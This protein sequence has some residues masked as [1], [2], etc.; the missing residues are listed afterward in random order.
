MVLVSLGG[1]EEA[2]AQQGY[3]VSCVC[4]ALYHGLL[5][6]RHIL[7]GVARLAGYS[8]QKRAQ[9]SPTSKDMRSSENLQSAS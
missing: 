8:I 4:D 3:F 5:K 1:C 6:T 7:E 2:K 9:G